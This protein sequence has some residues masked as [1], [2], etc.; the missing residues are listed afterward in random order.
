[1]TLKFSICCLTHGGRN[2]VQSGRNI[3]Q[4]NVYILFVS[5]YFRNPFKENKE[6]KKKKRQEILIFIKNITCQNKDFGSY[7]Q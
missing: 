1:M 5:K 4:S 3:I 6:D 7:S 2:Y